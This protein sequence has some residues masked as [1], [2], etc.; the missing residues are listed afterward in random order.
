MVE[1]IDI[2]LVK[3][4]TITRWKLYDKIMEDE[5]NKKLNSELNDTSLS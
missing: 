4:I 5:R 2:G 3:N 1:N